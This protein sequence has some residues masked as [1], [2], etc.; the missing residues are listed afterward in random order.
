MYQAGDNAMKRVPS[1]RMDVCP[2]AEK[3]TNDKFQARPDLSYDLLAHDPDVTGAARSLHEQLATDDSATV[4][5]VDDETS[6]SYFLKEL[7]ESAGYRALV[8]GN[9]PTALA[10]VRREQPDLI[11]TDC[12]MPEID[13]LEFIAR[14]QKTVMTARI[15]VVMMSS[16]RPPR[17]VPERTDELPRAVWRI[18]E[19]TRRGVY[20]AR[21]GD[22]FVPFVEKPFDLDVLL[23]VVDAATDTAQRFHN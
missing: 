14:L 23:K 2:N 1:T 16:I 8:A 4:L 6:I 18:L 12:M 7:L 10:L 20:I 15:P 22:R 17:E 21:V 11:L 5:V 13:G 19:H 3:I 9:V